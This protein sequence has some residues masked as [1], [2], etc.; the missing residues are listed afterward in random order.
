MIFGF[1]FFAKADTLGAVKNFYIESGYDLTARKSVT[2]VL[3]KVSDKAYFYVDESWWNFTDQSSILQSI[4]V[5]SQEFSSNIYPNLTAF[6]GSEWNPGIDSDTRIT[7]LIHPMIKD[8]GGYT[9]TIDEYSIYQNSG[10]NQR[11]MIYL[12]SD[13]IKTD[14]EKSL[15]AHEFVHLITFNQKD[16]KYGVSEDTWLD[17][18]RA[19]YAPTLLGYDNT[20][21]GSNL[22]KR[23]QSFVENPSISL[24]DWQNSKYNYGMANVFIQYLVDYYGKQILTNSLKSP[25][26]G[27]DSLNDALAKEGY[28]D[29][30]SQIFST[31]IVAVFL[32]DCG[33]GP[34]FCYKNPNLKDLHVV[35]QTNF[36]PLSGESTLT[37]ADNL[38]NWSANWYKIIGGKDILKI[39]FEGSSVAFSKVPYIT[40]NRS[41][42]FKVDFL[43][44]DKSNSASISIPNFGQDILSF[45]II[46]SI[47]SKSLAADSFYSFF[48]SASVSQNA[49]TD[50]DQ[51]QQLLARID[52]LKAEI[53]RLKSGQGSNGQ[54]SCSSIITN[55]SYGMKNTEV[56]CLQEFLKSRGAEIYPE[57]LITGYFGQ[58]TKNAVIKFQEKNGVIFPG[59]GFVGVLTR[60][61]INPIL[62]GV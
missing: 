13:Y 37:F 50:A 27:I 36:L 35:P 48:W 3:V 19:D 41:G 59:T 34:A 23:V 46:P 60:N 52:Y 16:R 54:F 39:K 22:Q 57:G 32:N 25:K 47:Y 12:N 10:S 53:A 15:L 55:L 51:I 42:N 49:N 38:K 31:W 33:Y 20:Y 6:F 61:K 30:F 29:N 8:A 56:R 14:Y 11:E 9:R 2:A 1:A 62:A 45:V 17:E 4:N 18:A 28:K 58:L 40:K 21:D 24:I 43:I 7:V 44:I 5:L 26:V